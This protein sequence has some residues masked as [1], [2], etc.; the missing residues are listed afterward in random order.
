MLQN[1]RLSKFAHHVVRLAGRSRWSERLALLRVPGMVTLRTSETGHIAC[2]VPCNSGIS[3][4]PVNCRRLT[5]PRHEQHRDDGKALDDVFSTPCASSA[6]HAVQ[7]TENSTGLRPRLRTSRILCWASTRASHSYSTASSG[8]RDWW[9]GR[10]RV[11]TLCGSEVGEVRPIR[12]ELLPSLSLCYVS[13]RPPAYF[14][15][16]VPGHASVRLPSDLLR[17]GITKFISSPLPS[18]RTVSSDASADDMMDDDR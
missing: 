12:S 14:E 15:G 8:P 9:E 4:R 13:G 1:T 6:H 10:D 18:G 11:V 7:C 3:R 17:Q 5:L 2:S 16:P